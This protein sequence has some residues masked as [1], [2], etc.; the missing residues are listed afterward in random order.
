MAPKMVDFTRKHHAKIRISSETIGIWRTSMKIVVIP[1]KM[2][3]LQNFIMISAT[4]M[5]RVIGNH[6]RS[7]ACSVAEDRKCAANYDHHGI[8]I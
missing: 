8:G 1:A 2:T 7:R 4:M 5:D 3:D 6:Q